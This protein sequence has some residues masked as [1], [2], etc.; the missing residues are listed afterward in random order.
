MLSLYVKIYACTVFGWRV[1]GGESE[2]KRKGHKAV[3]FEQGTCVDGR[4]TTM[5]KGLPSQVIGFLF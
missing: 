5:K 3:G 4:F 2:G 1:W